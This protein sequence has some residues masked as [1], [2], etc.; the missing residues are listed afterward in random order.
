MASTTLDMLLRIRSDLAGVQ[1]TQRE[2]Q[3]TV[4]IAQQVGPA[5]QAGVRSL[6]GYVATYASL[7]TIVRQVQDS[8]SYAS[9]M[10]DQAYQA[11]MNVMDLQA[12]QAVGAQ[13][14]VQ[15]ERIGVSIAAMRTRAMEAVTGNVKLRKAFSD[16]NVD[17]KDFYGM[18]TERKLEALAVGFANATDK[19]AAFN[20]M[21][22]IFGREQGPRLV[23]LLDSIGKDGLVKVR[24]NAIA[25]GLALE[26][27]ELEVLDR[28]DD[29]LETL[30]LKI[31]VLTGRV[32]AAFANDDT[33]AAIWDMLKLVSEGLWISIKNTFHNVAIE[34]PR[35]LINDMKAFFSW[36]G[37]SM[38]LVAKSFVLLLQ[39]G[40]NAMVDKVNPLLKKLRL[41]QMSGIDTSGTR[42]ETDVL[43]ERM[44]NPDGYLDPNKSTVTSMSGL[45]ELF[46]AKPYG[47]PDNQF[48]F[49]AMA[50]MRGFSKASAGDADAGVAGG[51]GGTTVDTP[52]FSAFGEKMTGL[53]EQLGSFEDIVANNFTGMFTAGIDTISSGLSGLLMKTQTLGQSLRGIWNGFVENAVSAFSKMI[54]E[55]AV[56]KAAMFAV[57]AAMAAKGLALSVAGAAKSMVA[58]IPAAIAAVIGSGWAGLA[59]AAAGTVAVMA[60]LGSFAEGGYTGAGGKYDAAGVVHRGEYV[61]PADVVSRMGVGYFDAIAAGAVTSPGM[62]APATDSGGGIAS[63][64]G[65]G[66]S[67]I[68]MVDDSRTSIRKAM[69]STE[70]KRH[71]VRTVRGQS[72]R[73]QSD[74]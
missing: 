1:S 25:A 9:R 62:M 26:G 13:V 39:E 57:D 37:D 19:Q 44:K 64:A 4:G 48:G 31:K 18:P 74:F 24:Q 33:R 40:I 17:L 23:E 72:H 50:L 59:L 51:A 68:I 66:S 29:K 54:A 73:I 3:K 38:K 60:A 42:A 12:I 28:L 61:V 58:W 49:G 22:Q 20:A 47:N 56:S 10:S 53:Q 7:R 71:I 52:K 15:F 70:G 46:S 16:L 6:M 63:M 36:F 67:S 65:G 41:G 30:G 69:E 2:L 55:Y 32:T 43:R 11:S 27:W 45:A 35:A 8:I 34:F 14:G 21:T 5:V